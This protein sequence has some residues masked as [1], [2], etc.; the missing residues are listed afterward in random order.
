MLEMPYKTPAQRAWFD[1]L[2]DSI[3]IQPMFRYTGKDW[4]HSRL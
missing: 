2:Y 1:H 4:Q 3:P